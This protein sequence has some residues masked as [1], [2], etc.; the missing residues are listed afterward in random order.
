MS[1]KL[2]VINLLKKNMKFI[3]PI[4][5]SLLLFSCINSSQKSNECCN[6]PNKLV[7][8]WE[9]QNAT[10]NDSSMTIKEPRM[11]KIFTDSVM[12][13]QYYDQNLFCGDS[14]K[15][16]VLAT[17]YGKYFYFNGRV[18]KLTRREKIYK[19]VFLCTINVKYHT[20][21]SYYAYKNINI[22]KNIIVPSIM[23]KNT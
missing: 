16:T 7:G 8:V 3:L 21:V 13:Y 11:V 15:K 19:L 12:I 20:H 5:V 14:A 22:I 1:F 4:S 23:I 2:K 18:Q 9:L 17:G 6:Q 10:W